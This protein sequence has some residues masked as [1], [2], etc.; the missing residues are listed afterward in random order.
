MIPLK[1]S[2]IVL[3]G[4]MGCGKTT[5][6][7]KLSERLK[8]PF[9]DLD[10]EIEKI[11]R[12]SIAEIFDQKGAIYFRNLEKKVLLWVLEKKESFVLA[13]GGGTPCY[14]NNMQLI[15]NTHGVSSIYLDCSIP[16]LTDRLYDEMK[17]RPMLAGIESKEELTEFIGKH[18][19][20][21]RP[22]Y[23]QAHHKVNVGIQ[24]PD[25]I[26]NEINSNLRLH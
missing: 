19:F 16:Q 13:L 10:K 4:Y 1:D 25:D 17:T 5:T 14:F 22:Y 18:L 21:R 7:K 20:E 3:S 9:Y 23:L 2:K 24:S 12:L 15:N 6:G 26:V 11:E 8:I